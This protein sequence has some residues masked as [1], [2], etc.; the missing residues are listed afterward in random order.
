M[1]PS[2]PMSSHKPV[3]TCIAC[4]KR[5]FKNK[6][7]RIVRTPE[8]KIEVDISYDKP[9]RGAYLCFSKDCFEQAFRK[10]QVLRSLNVPV[11]PAFREELAKLLD[12]KK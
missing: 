9:G 7:L 10:K 6:L 3:R 11:P 2:S 1:I 8:N 5:N 4:R 12:D